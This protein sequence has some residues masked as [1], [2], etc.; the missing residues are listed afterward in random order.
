MSEEEVPPSPCG[1]IGLIGQPSVSLT[2]FGY[3]LSLSV[4]ECQY[5]VWYNESKILLFDVI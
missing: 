1:F 5:K 4:Q 3:P 2:S